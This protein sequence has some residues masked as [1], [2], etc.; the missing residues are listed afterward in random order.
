[1]DESL[2][3]LQ[4]ATGWPAAAVFGAASANSNDQKA[5]GVPLAVRQ[6]IADM[7]PLD[8]R[9]Y[10]HALQRFVAGRAPAA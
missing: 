3:R 5:A 7:N 10:A 4:A 8:M 9:L 1:M 6:A 2:A